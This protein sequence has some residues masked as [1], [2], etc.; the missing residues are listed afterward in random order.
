MVDYLTETIKWLTDNIV[1]IGIFV[2]VIY[3]GYMIYR[4]TKKVPPVPDFIK[5]W[6]DRAV[7]EEKLNKVEKKFGAKWLYRGEEYLGQI[8]T[9]GKQK[10]KVNMHPE[11][12]KPQP[13]DFAEKE[14]VT[15]TF[16]PQVF[17]RIHS[18]KRHILRFIDGEAR[19]EN[20]KLVFPSYFTFTSFGNE[21]ISLAMIQPTTKVIEDNWNKRLYEASANAFANQMLKI[22]GYLTEFA[23]QRKVQ[24]LEIEKMKAERQMKMGSII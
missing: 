24:E 22:S 8:K 6:K 15:I 18:G 13:D 2:A 7:D 21:F 10:Y 16:S 1:V 9:F 5:V 12:D 20:G 23:Q 14:V 3:F 19:M 4:Q 11:K 17:G